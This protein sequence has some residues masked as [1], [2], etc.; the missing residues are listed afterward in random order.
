M[1][2]TDY[3]RSFIEA[4]LVK[5]GENTRRMRYMVDTGRLGELIRR[6]VGWC[7]YATT[8]PSGRKGSWKKNKIISTGDL[9]DDT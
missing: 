3:Y 4:L 9:K 1:I 7:L 5:N 8:T 2:L 6:D